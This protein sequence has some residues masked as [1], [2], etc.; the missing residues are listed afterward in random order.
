[1]RERF[2][3]ERVKRIIKWL[4]P[5]IGIKRWIMVSAFGIVLVIMGVINLERENI[6]LPVLLKILGII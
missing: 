3:L 5:G 6:F 1:M 4:Y 2:N